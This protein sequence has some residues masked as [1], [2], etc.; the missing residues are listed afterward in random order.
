MQ[1][2]A[3]FSQNYYPQQISSGQVDKK[4]A[5]QYNALLLYVIKLYRTN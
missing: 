2:L 1:E 5:K 3:I 4:T